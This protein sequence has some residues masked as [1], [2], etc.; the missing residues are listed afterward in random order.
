LDVGK[1][2]IEADDVGVTAMRVAQIVAMGT[3]V[4]IPATRLRHDP[5]PAI[6]S[7]ELLAVT[8]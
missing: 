6:V 4:D 5:L 3:F 8:S 7:L 2:L 1:H